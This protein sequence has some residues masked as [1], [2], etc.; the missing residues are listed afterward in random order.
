V[1]VRSTP[2]GIPIEEIEARLR[3]TQARLAD[4]GFA[5]LLSYAD[6]WR[7]A[8]VRYFSDFHGIDGVH[9]IARALLLIPVSGEPLLFVGGS[10]DPYAQSMSSFPVTTFAS[11]QSELSNWVKSADAGPV[12]LAGEGIIPAVLRDDVNAALDPLTITPTDILARQ[13]AV[14]S[15]WE[16]T[17]MREAGRLTDHAMETIRDL[18]ATGESFSERDLA[19]AA[20]AAMIEAGADGPGYLS[21]VQ[22]G[23]RSEFP[24]AM[25]TDRVLQQGELV[26]TDIGARYGAYVADGGRGFAYGP[27]S[28]AQRD[29]IE[30]AADSVEAG[31]AAMKPGMSAAELNALMQDLLVERGYEEY[32]SE[33]SGRGVGHGTGMDAEE[34][35]PWIGPTDGTVLEPGMV[36][37]LKTTINVPKIGGVRSERIVHLSAEGADPLDLFP[38][39]N[40]W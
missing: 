8:N 11:M 32:S 9:D 6:T 34:E 16:V 28:D 23:P 40:Y 35:L 21:M 7:T 38:M 37:T 36:F 18:L 22:S 10:C 26:L 13:K 39:R 3:E 33:A 27:V 1:I 2:R 5:A 24:L 12:A 30:S 31:L 17:Q 15:P 14:K 19:R 20:D 25:P 4:A 29:I